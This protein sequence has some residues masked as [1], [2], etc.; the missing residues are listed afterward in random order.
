MTDTTDY[1]YCAMCQMEWAN[2]TEDGHRLYC[3]GCVALDQGREVYGRMM[4]ILMGS[5]GISE[6]EANIHALVAEANTMA[7]IDEASTNQSR[8]D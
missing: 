5:Y 3:P 4:Q 7:L 8:L 1:G 2:A 6:D